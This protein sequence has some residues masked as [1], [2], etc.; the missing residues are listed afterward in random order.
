MESCHEY[1]PYTALDH[2]FFQG[3]AARMI[4]QIL[5]HQRFP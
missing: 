2:V 3:R 4:H 1:T 5:Y